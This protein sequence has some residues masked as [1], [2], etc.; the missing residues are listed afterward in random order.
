LLD[1]RSQATSS[2]TEH[3]LQPAVVPVATAARR[4]PAPET[5]ESSR[6]DRDRTASL[7]DEGGASAVQFEAR[8]LRPDEPADEAAR[9]RL[10]AALLALGALLLWIAFLQ[11]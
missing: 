8:G 11:D 6:L 10:L 9:M 3:S 4:G 1:R 2:G 7:A 5:E